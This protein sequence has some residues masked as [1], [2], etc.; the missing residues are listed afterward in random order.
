MSRNEVWSMA[1]IDRTALRSLLP[2]EASDLLIP[3]AKA[4]DLLI[5][6]QTEKRN[7]RANPP[8]LRVFFLPSP[9]LALGNSDF[10]DSRM[11]MLVTQALCSVL[12]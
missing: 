11:G 7:L 4:S 1:L 3:A 8:F 12:R 5:T 10:Q 2:A 9:E 6:G